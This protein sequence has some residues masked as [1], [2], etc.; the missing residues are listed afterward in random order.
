[1]YKSANVIRIVKPRRVWWAGIIDKLRQKKNAYRTLRS[2][3]PKCPL[4]RL[5]EITE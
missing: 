2:P 1:L 4:E 5:K 3:L